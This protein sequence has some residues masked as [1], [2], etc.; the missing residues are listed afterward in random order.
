MLWHSFLFCSISALCSLILCW[1][2]VLYSW[3]S[4]FRPCSAAQGWGREARV[5]SLA[6]WLMKIQ[7]LSQ[8]VQMRNRNYRALPNTGFHHARPV[9]VWYH[10]LDLTPS[11]SSKWE[12]FP[13]WACGSLLAIFIECFPHFHSHHKHRDLSF[14]IFNSF[15][16][17]LLHKSNVMMERW[18]MD[19]LP[20]LPSSGS[21]S[22]YVLRN[23]QEYVFIFIATYK[24]SFMP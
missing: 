19:C 8:Q 23:V 3:R 18:P 13:H 10:C 21:S 24:N 14:D 1:V 20:Q 12:A 17:W 9:T 4:G 7:R 16:D 22:L 2:T 15:K 11:W 6:F 5:S